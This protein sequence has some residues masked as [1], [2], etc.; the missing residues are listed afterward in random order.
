MS[1]WVAL[2]AC[3]AAEQGKP[4]AWFLCSPDDKRWRMSKKT[5]QAIAARMNE[6]ERPTENDSTCTHRSSP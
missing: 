6:P 1:E 4:G 3:Y 2:P 5:A